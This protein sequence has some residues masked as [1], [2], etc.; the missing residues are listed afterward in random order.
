MAFFDKVSKTVYTD[1]IQ[2]LRWQP[3]TY[4]TGN[5]CYFT[6]KDI[7]VRLQDETDLINCYSKCDIKVRSL[8]DLIDNVY[9]KDLIEISSTD[10]I[11]NNKYCHSN[12]KRASFSFNRLGVFLGVP[13]YRF[14]QIRTTTDKTDKEV[15]QFLLKNYK[16]YNGIG[17]ELKKNNI[18]PG[19]YY[20]RLKSGW[21]KEKAK[22]TPVKKI[23]RTYDH[24]GNEFSNQK[25]MLKHY[26]ISQAQFFRRK[27][28]GLSLEQCLAPTEQKF[29]AFKKVAKNTLEE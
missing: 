18:P 3:Y 14:D 1:A 19:V 11:L 4:V 16:G 8:S 7:H 24:K 10:Y 27:K 15:L 6:Y 17:D 21:D 20:A 28:K 25:E 2:N 13:K 29:N 9:I 26:G 22:T 12:S 23:G 5:R